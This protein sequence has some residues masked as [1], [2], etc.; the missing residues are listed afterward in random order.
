[1][2]TRFA[3]LMFICAI[4]SAA[5]PAAPP[6]DMV[7]AKAAFAE[8]EAVSNKEGGHLW[9]KKLYG[10]LFFVDP[11]TRYVVANEPDSEDVLHATDGVFVGTLP[12]EILL[13]NA[14][15]EWQGKRWTMLLWPTIPTDTIDRRIIFAHELFHRIQP[16][17]G[18]M[19]PD[20]PNLQLDTPE[21]RLW[22]QLEWRALAAAL[23]NRGLRKPG[24]SAMRSLSAAIATICLPDPPR[25]KQASKSPKV[26][27]NIRG[28][29]PVNLT[30][31]RRGGA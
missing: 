5:P 2:P 21:G 9:G 19:A 12:K 3:L 10:A 23:S 8:A 28:R 14:P 11:E 4:A 26:F 13:A 18:L 1:M 27:P 6:I 7:Q 15:V 25:R 31:I 16:G 22:L 30:A 29:L 24:P 20:S 17:L